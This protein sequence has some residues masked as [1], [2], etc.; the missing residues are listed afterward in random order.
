M[1]QTA[2]VIVGPPCSGLSVLANV[3]SLFG[4]ALPSESLGPQ[5]DLKANALGRSPLAE[6][7]REILLAYGGTWDR[8]G[9]WLDP[10]L[11]FSDTRKALSEEIVRKYRDRARDAIAASFPSG[12]RPMF[13]DPLTVLFLPLWTDALR[14]LGCEPRIVLMC[15]NPLATAAS[16][17]ML[18]SSVSQRHGCQL[19]L[20]YVLAALAD[21]NLASVVLYEDLV[22]RPDSIVP[23]LL[24]DCGVDAQES[25]SV[26]P[27][28]DQILSSLHK[29][30][31]V[32]QERLDNAPHVGP[33]VKETWQFVVTWRSMTEAEKQRHIW[34]LQNNFDNSMLLVTSPTM[35]RSMG[36]SDGAAGSSVVRKV[37]GIAGLPRSGTTLL[38]SILGVHSDIFAI[39]EPWNA[40]KKAGSVRNAINLTEFLEQTKP[41]L[42][43][44]TN[45]LI[46]ETATQLQY[47]ENLQHLLTTL[48]HE[49]ERE[50]LILVRNPLHT[51]LS[52]VQA[53]REWW[54]EEGLQITED[55]VARWAERT[56]KAVVFLDRMGAAHN[57]LLVSYDALA[58][59]VQL[60]ETIMH[61]IE[62][63]LEAR[64]Y[65]YEK[66]LDTKIVRGDVSVA[67]GPR[68]ITG[69]SIAKRE[70]EAGVLRRMCDNSK[71]KDCF[72]KLMDTSRRLEAIG[73]VRYLQFGPFI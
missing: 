60:I 64:Q 21:E 15:R 46:K 30:E 63:P 10:A 40:T 66:H 59:N 54:G 41:R 31:T 7:N 55:L 34:N 2:L 26:R 50:L 24:A 65:E 61:E 1:V 49:V 44:K 48:D 3:A 73:A 19:W 13:I 72:D 16:L 52:E 12:G 56:L 17:K 69:D 14:A 23:S 6:L 29:H 45:L 58:K 42:V 67:A 70:L 28:I 8:P 35:V 36:S 62:I 43:N 39:Y 51:L 22:E 33:L 18:D 57:A 37:I 27:N 25:E 5:S 38:T 68:P 71:Q 47:L 20:L 4:F 32:S 11:G 53:R 9:P